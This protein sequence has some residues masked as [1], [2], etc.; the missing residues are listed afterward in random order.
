MCV[1]LAPDAERAAEECVHLAHTTPDGPTVSAAQAVGHDRT[2]AAAADV[3]R[4]YA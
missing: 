2:P 1:R 4:A 3:V